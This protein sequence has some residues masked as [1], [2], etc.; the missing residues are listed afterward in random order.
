MTKIRELNTQLV[1]LVDKGGGIRL[2]DK[3]G[4]LLEEL[5]LIDVVEGLYA[6]NPSDGYIAHKID[7]IRMSCKSGQTYFVVGGKNIEISC[8]FLGSLKALKIFKLKKKES[9]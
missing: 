1:E 8:E 2:V 9:K 3:D 7:S 5:I 6:A 4:V